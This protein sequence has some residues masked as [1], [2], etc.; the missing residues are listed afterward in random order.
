MDIT[1][2]DLKILIANA[3][4]GELETLNQKLDTV[5]NMKKVEIEKLNE[6]MAKMSKVDENKMKD[7]A[8]EKL[9]DEKSKK[10]GKWESFGEQ[11]TAVMKACS[12]NGW[13][14][15]RL[16]ATKDISGMNETAGAEGGFLVNPEYSAEIFKIQHDAGQ[17]AKDCRHIPIAGNTLIIN[18][19]NETSRARGSHWGGTQTYWVAEG[20]TATKSDIKFRQIRL[21]L[22]KLMCIQYSTEELSADQTA[23]A[24]L[25]TQAVGEEFAFEIDDAI[26]NGTGAGQPLGVRKCAALKTVAKDTLQPADTVSATNIMEMYNAMPALN[27]VNANW[28]MIQDVE[29]QIWK[30]YI[31]IGTAGVPVYMPATGITGVPNGTLLG[32][33]I[34]VVEQCQKLGDEGDILFLD[35]SQYLI[36]EKTTGI[37]ATSSIHVRFLYDE[38]TFKFTYR[39]D[40]QPLWNSV[41]TAFN[42]AVTRS[43]YVTL[44]ERA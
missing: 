11:M 27:R 19:V 42:S 5:E 21:N 6:Q 40:G 28:Y 32:R 38:N 1:Q 15:K 9:V 39:L 25:T 31:P 44:A 22:H 35:L 17:I 12:P 4:K 8:I 30:M 37:T 24:S 13:V 29:P 2:E 18:G 20:G 3:F 33:P 41:L 14:D 34:K 10:E 7:V 16:I 36:I 43:P 23:L 26:L